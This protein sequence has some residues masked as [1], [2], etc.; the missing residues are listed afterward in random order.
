MADQSPSMRASPKTRHG[1]EFIM[2]IQ[3]WV[4]WK[5]EERDDG[6]TKPPIAPFDDRNHASTID[7]TTWTTHDKA[8]Q[9]HDRDDT[10]TDGIGIVLTAKDSFVGI[11]LDGCRDPNTGKMEGWATDIIETVDSYTEV[12]PSG[13][14]VRIFATGELPESGKQALQKRTVFAL[15]GCEKTPKI[16]M[17][18]RNQYLTYSAD[19]I[20]DTPTNIQ[21]RHDDVNTV[22]D[23]YLVDDTS[24]ETTQTTET[25]TTAETTPTIGNDLSN[26]EVIEK[27]LSAANGRVFK[28]LSD[29][30]D[31]MHNGDTSKADLAFTQ[32]LAFWTGGDKNQMDRLFR[33]SDRMRDKWDE[34][35][36]SDGS[37]YGDMTIETAMTK[38]SDFYK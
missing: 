29:G 24:E 38:Q 10:D 28:K 27:G 30:D 7:S 22:Y 37:T 13:Y 35:H 32:I 23:E 4:C 19:H 31:S 11:D 36:H 5:Y 8:Q 25:T 18:D 6:F 3:Q 15:A 21:K 12:S 17:Y 14:G 33:R 1:G 9:Y 16:E 20:D 26:D 34:T 2:V